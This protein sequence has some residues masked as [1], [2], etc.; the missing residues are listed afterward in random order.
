[1]A[2]LAAVVS[3]SACGSAARQDAN[4]PSGN[5]TVSVPTA[6]FPTSQ[7]LAQHSNLVIAVRNDSGKT[8]PNVAVTICNVTC[9]YPAPP[10]EGTSAGAFAQDLTQP[11]LANPSR[12]VWVVDQPPGQC[13]YSCLSGGP[14]GA[15]TAYSN[16]WALG[17]LKPGA[18]ATFNW[19]VT[20][21]KAGKHTVAWE[22]AAG[23][24][25]KAK[26]VLADG[27]TPRGTFAVTINNAPQ[28]SYV[29]DQGQVVKAP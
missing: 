26:A 20:P 18:I 2:G 17:P 6:S 1:V 3:L 28:Q 10:G 13:I 24:A 4:E 7:R 22:V 29:N 14:G 9:S 5:F 8:I 15:V 12:P 23:L 16:T 27:S 25:G 11:N 21:V 19:A